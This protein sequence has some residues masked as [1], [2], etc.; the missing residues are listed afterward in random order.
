MVCA[1]LGVAKSRPETPSSHI[2][3][4]GA[5]GVFE[6]ERAGPVMWLVLRSVASRTSWTSTFKCV[7]KV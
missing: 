3:Y 5:C 4:T 1:V 6:T 2:C 7:K